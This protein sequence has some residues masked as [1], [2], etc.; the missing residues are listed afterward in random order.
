[1]KFGFAAALL[2][3]LIAAK[4]SPQATRPEAP[5]PLRAWKLAFVRG[6]NIW[7]ANGDGTGQRL[8]LRN[9]SAPC[10]S[11]DK[12]RIAFVR[13][14]N[15]WVANADGSHPRRLTRHWKPRS[16]IDQSSP[17]DDDINLAWNPTDNLIT[18]SHWEKFPVR[19]AGDKESDLLLCSSLFEVSP[20]S[21]LTGTGTLLFDLLEQG[22]Y[23]SF[24]DNDAPAF[25]RSGKQMAFTRNGDIWVA[26]RGQRKG[27]DQERAWDAWEWDVTRIAAP[28]QFDDPNFRGS[29]ENYGVTHL[30]WSPDG[31]FLAYGIR[32]L[33]GSG[34]W[35]IHVLS[36]GKDRYGRP[37]VLQNRLLANDGVDPCFSPDGRFI[38]YLG[39][40]YGDGLGDIKVLS[41]DGRLNRRLI[42][43]AEQPAW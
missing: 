42:K 20:S 23:Y 22:A 10:W 15:I 35:E 11:P 19:R 14:G 4:A 2:F 30:S 6:G 21:P 27:R 25:S 13:A 36:V 7:V 18:Y 31:R 26:E 34:F 8:L 41:L 43:D 40:S 38:A 9:A 3:C 37:I 29:R 1:M 24:G 16:G 12:K 5:E 17:D 28:A 39:Q 32:R 33:G